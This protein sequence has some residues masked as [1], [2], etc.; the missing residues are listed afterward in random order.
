MSDISANE[1]VEL[2]EFDEQALEQAAEQAFGSAI[3]P[4]TSPDAGPVQPPAEEPEGESVPSIPDAFEYSPGQSLTRQKIENY[5]SFDRLLSSDPQL[6]RLI[7]NYLRGEPAP[8][9]D[10]QSERPVTQP[11]GS[12]YQ[13]GMGRQGTGFPTAPALPQSPQLPPD[14]DLSDPTTAYLVGMVNQMGQALQ[15]Y[16]QELSRQREI[17]GNRV[18]ADNQTVI[19]NATQQFRD[20]YALDDNDISLLKKGAAGLQVI[21]S[22]MECGIDP[23]TGEPTSPDG[24]NAVTKA[25]EYAAHAIPSIRAKILAQ[26]QIQSHTDTTRRHKLQAVGGNS[27]PAPRTPNTPTTPEARRAGLLDEV[28]ANLST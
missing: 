9:I 1:P 14:V 7:Y 5:A 26:E 13:E 21:Q 17:V 20:R 27:R 19:D 24:F 18:A 10:H 11:T 2:P 15:N 22:I 8:G 3:S 12:V 4:G 23:L 25:Y 16:H 28:R 6:S